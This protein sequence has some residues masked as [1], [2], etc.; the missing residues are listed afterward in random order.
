MVVFSDDLDK[1]IAAFIIANGALAMGQEVS[2][3]FTF[4]GLNS[5]R[6]AHPPQREKT[7]MDRMFGAMMPRGADKLKL[8]QMHMAGA[9]TAMI[10][11]VMKQHN[12]PRL[13]DLISAAQADGAR[14]LGCTM[15][16][17]LLGMAHSDLVDG[18]ELAGVATFLG[19]AQESGTTLFI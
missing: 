16:M 7:L 12:V 3:F 15:T 4:W 18:V 9:G 6:K 8:S 14:L 2:M 17:D 13:P 11:N 1:Q 10:Q 5:L 19:E